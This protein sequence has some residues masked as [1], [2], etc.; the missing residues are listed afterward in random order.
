MNGGAEL[1]IMQCVQTKKAYDNL[2]KLA[3]HQKETEWWEDVI[4]SEKKLAKAKS[5]NYNGT[6]L[7]GNKTSKTIHKAIKRLDF[8]NN[9]EFWDYLL[10]EDSID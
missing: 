2:W 4:K 3:K 9:M 6:I 10:Y 8:N 5:G 1:K 7:E